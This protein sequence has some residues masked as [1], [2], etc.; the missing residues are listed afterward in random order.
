MAKEAALGAP[1]SL[2]ASPLRGG[3]TLEVV[4]HH[5]RKQQDLCEDRATLSSSISGTIIDGD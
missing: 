3:R 2:P 5:I 1:P 4:Q